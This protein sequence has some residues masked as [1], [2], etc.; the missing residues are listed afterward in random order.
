MLQ[1]FYIIRPNITKEE[2]NMQNFFNDQDIENVLKE[3]GINWDKP[4]YKEC[5]FRFGDNIIQSKVDLQQDRS[6]NR[7]YLNVRNVE[8]IVDNTMLIVNQIY[9]N[10]YSRYDASYPRTFLADLTPE[11]TSYLQE[12]YPEYSDIIGIDIDF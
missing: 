9:S 2:E 5:T 6:P 4:Y 3:N 12:K 8:I 7:L 11:W 10:T 1:Y